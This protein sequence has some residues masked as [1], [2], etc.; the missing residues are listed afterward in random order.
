MDLIKTSPLAIVSILISK[1]GQV[2]NGA[3]HGNQN[4]ALF[5]YKPPPAFM[6]PDGINFFTFLLIFHGKH[7]AALPS[8]SALKLGGH[9]FRWL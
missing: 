2:E 4:W 9:T 7:D 6:E 1:C 8:V 5:N 3:V